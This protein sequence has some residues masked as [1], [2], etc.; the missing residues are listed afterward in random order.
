[1]G[2]DQKLKEATMELNAGTKDCRGRVLQ[3]GDEIILITPG[4]VFFRVASIQPSLD[5]LAPKDLLLLQIGAMIPFVAKRGAINPEFVRV[6]T[7]E[8]AGPT[9]FE[10]LPPKPE[11]PTR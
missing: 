6:R 11:D 8:E 1:M 4:P 7:A 3:E 5:P 10:T 9:P 2:R